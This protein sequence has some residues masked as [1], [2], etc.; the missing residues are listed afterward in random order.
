MLIGTSEVRLNV[1]ATGSTV[2]V[3]LPVVDKE[4]LETVLLNA[5]FS[6]VVP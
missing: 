4:T 1:S 6:N 3:Q 5:P 2:L